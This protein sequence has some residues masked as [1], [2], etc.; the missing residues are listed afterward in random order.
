[1]AFTDIPPY[2]WL[3]PAKSIGDPNGSYTPRSYNTANAEHRMFVE[4]PKAGNISKVLFLVGTMTVTGDVEVRL[5]GWD[6]L[7]DSD[8][9]LINV[10]AKGAQNI[11]DTDDNETFVVALDAAIP[12]TRG[13][14]IAVVIKND[15]STPVSGQIQT[16]NT[17]N[18]SAQFPYQTEKSNTQR[19]EA[20]VVGFEYD[21]G[22]YEKVLGAFPV[23]SIG[24]VGYASDDAT[25]DE[26]A[27]RFKYPIGIR[28]AGF[29]GA[30]RSNTATTTYDL[31]LYDPVDAVLKTVTPD[32]DMAENEFSDGIKKYMFTSQVELLADTVYRL[33]LKPTSVAA[34][35]VQLHE[36]NL[37]TAAVMGGLDCGKE[38]HLST[39]KDAGAW[40]DD[41]AIRPFLGLIVDGLESPGGQ[42]LSLAGLGSTRG[43]FQ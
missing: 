8:G 20:P 25:A 23:S 21:D 42:G 30:F 22:T 40:S 34:N 43:G 35:R 37:N 24:N 18:W 16:L 3:P 38:F 28:V 5:E 10:N 12:V 14:Q 41:G 17:D 4:V 9:T 2:L 6:G 13:Q 39:R 36:W 1:M 15:G 29:W 26:R 33:S 19:R 32:P 27:L 11:L 7:G 31:V